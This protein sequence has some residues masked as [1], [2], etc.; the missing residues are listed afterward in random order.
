MGE[1]VINILGRNIHQNP[2][3]KK[4]KYTVV[5]FHNIRDGRINFGVLYCRII[6]YGILR[7]HCQAYNF[8]EILY[9]IFEELF[10]KVWLVF[11]FAEN[12]FHTVFV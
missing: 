6:I 5:L 8:K 4:N 9:S 12:I 2:W 3:K 1:K 10:I 7:T 11:V